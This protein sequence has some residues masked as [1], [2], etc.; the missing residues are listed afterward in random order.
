MANTTEAVVP[1]ERRLG[2]VLGLAFG[3][4]IGDPVEFRRYP[5]ISKHGVQVPDRFRVTDDT[6]MSLAVWSALEAW[7]MPRTMGDVNGSL[8][9]LRIE[10]FASFVSWLHDPD[11]NRAPGA[12]CIG[13]L[14]QLERVGLGSWSLATSATS[15]GCGSVM[16]APWVGLSD[17]LTDEMVERVAM[18]Q[19]VLTHGPAENAYCAAALAAL[20][21]AVARD[22]VAPGGAADYLLAWSEDRA[23][24]SY[25]RAVL[26]DLWRVTRQSDDRAA[27]HD[28]P[29]SYRD[30]GLAHV[31]WVVRAAGELTGELLGSPWGFDPAVVS[32]EG[33]RA[34]EAVALAVGV[35]DAFDA[36]GPVSALLRAA[37]TSGDS[38]SVAAITGALV[39]AHAGA[40]A[41]PA[42]WLLRLEPRYQAEL[43]RAGGRA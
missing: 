2:S 18:L 34:R 33:W 10:L 38:D 41:F 26:G 12:T 42:A 24:F 11:N 29:E 9:M 21:R 37:E 14:S 32:G 36:Y 17:K 15:A 16:R 31:R 1:A 27:G 35:F 7:E 39:G 8:A 22:E 5:E 25:D 43:M 3:D 40:D 19:A 28:S 4:A 6:Q 13:A 23:L 20:T 30:E